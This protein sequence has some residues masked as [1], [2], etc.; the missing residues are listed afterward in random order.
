[1]LI[2]LVPLLAAVVLGPMNQDA[3][4]A[5]ILG[6]VLVVDELKKTANVDPGMGGVV[7]F[8]GTA[9]AVEMRNLNAQY[10]IID[11]DVDAGE[12]R[13][14]EIPT[15]VVSRGQTIV[16]FSFSVEV[17]QITVTSGLVEAQIVTISGSWSYEPGLL[18]GDI[19][20]MTGMIYVD[21]FYQCS[22]GC[23]SPYIQTAPGGRIE[24]ELLIA[25]EGNGDD[26]INLEVHNRDH[27]D[28]EGWVVEQFQNFYQLK[29][30]ETIK[31]SIGVVAPKNWDPWV[32]EITFIKFHVTSTQAGLTQNVG[33]HVYYSV[34][35]RQ[36]GASVPGFE[37]PVVLFSILLVA[38]LTIH[39][40]YAR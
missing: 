33:E 26:K 39:K 20:P 5:G 40:R 31:V 29:R 35:I 13:V 36:R 17:P 19:E 1:M 34:Y 7:T 30:G 37:V 24:I 16:S 14:T 4:G 6:V 2:I 38:L 10:A 3:E 9:Q 18:S 27:L 11:I 12:W 22:I 32:N 28:N 15:I 21:Q 23:E 8:T 25:N